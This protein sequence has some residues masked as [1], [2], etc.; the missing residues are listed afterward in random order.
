MDPDFCIEEETFYDEELEGELD[1]ACDD[2]N[3]DFF[4]GVEDF[5]QFEHDADELLYPDHLNADQLG[6]A[7]AFGDLVSKD[8]E[9]YDVDE[10]TDDENWKNA[11]KL[12]PLQSRYNTSQDLSG[13]EKYISGITSGQTKGPWRRD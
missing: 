11:M 7:M 5:D 12:Y 4:R 9:E 2:W 1:R 3:E 13:F 6:L 10:D 8:K